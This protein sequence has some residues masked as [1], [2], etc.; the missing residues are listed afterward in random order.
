MFTQ[1]KAARDMASSP[2]GRYPLGDSRTPTSRSSENSVQANL[3]LPVPLRTALRRMRA[4]VRGERLRHP[5]PQVPPPSARRSWARDP[6]NLPSSE[7]ILR[8]SCLTRA[9][10]RTEQ[11]ALAPA[12]EVAHEGRDSGDQVRDARPRLYYHHPQHVLPCTAGHA[13]L[14]RRRDGSGA[15]S[16]VGRPTHSGC[17]TVAAKGPECALRSIAQPHKIPLFAGFFTEWAML[18]SNQRPPPCKGGALPLS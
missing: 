17:S 2:G 14:C 5:T 7:T 12:A 13:G 3:P 1:L 6:V 16:F 8:W 10:R 11:R 18:G 4:R 9:A 15:S